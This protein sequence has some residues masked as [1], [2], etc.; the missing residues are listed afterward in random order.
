MFAS[1]LVQ[2]LIRGALQFGYNRAID[3]AEKFPDAQVTAVDI[4]PMLPRFVPGDLSG[5]FPYQLSP[6]ATSTIV[7]S[8]PTF[9][10]SSSTFWSI[11]Y[12]GNRVPSM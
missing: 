12:H 10:S 3:I 11:H 6:I 2:Y 1:S 8:P 5:D 4:G 9:N 7:Q